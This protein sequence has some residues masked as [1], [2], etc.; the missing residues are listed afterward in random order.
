MQVLQFQIVVTDLLQFVSASPLFGNNVFYLL[1]SFSASLLA[2]R[3]ILGWIKQVKMSN[4]HCPAFQDEN[5]NTGIYHR[6][7]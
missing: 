2:V 7:A 3:I 5:P 1:K 4:K 6:E